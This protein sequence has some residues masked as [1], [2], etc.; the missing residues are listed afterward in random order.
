VKDV[1]DT[2]PE[3]NKS[4]GYIEATLAIPEK[5]V[6]VFAAPPDTLT[7]RNVEAV[8][9]LS[10]RVYLEVIREPTFPL[11]VAKLG[12]L[13]IVNRAAFVHW[14]EQQN[15]Q[16]AFEPCNDLDEDPSS[17]TIGGILDMVGLERSRELPKRRSG[18]SRRRR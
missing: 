17:I 2:G 13:R 18:T 7:Q 6:R 3:F 1:N 15:E 16:A 9:G 5:A 12:K 10:S 8:T 4:G 14:L 11:R